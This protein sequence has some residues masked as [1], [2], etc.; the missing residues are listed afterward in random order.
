MTASGCYDRFI[1]EAE[2]QKFYH[3]ADVVTLPFVAVENTAVAGRRDG[4]RK[5]VL[6]PNLGVIGE[7]LCHQRELVYEPGHLEPAMAKLSILTPARIAQIGELNFQEI[8]RY[9]WG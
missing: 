3:A 6:A 7:R 5:P 2:L 9:T 8:R 1:P 4:F